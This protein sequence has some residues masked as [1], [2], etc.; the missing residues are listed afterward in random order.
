MTAE[1]RLKIELLYDI[2][3]GFSDGVWWSL[4]NDHEITIEDF[5]EYWEEKK[6]MNS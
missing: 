3:S 4:C 1:K 2:G 5:E 6:A